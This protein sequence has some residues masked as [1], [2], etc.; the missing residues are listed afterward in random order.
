MKALQLGSILIVISILLGACSTNSPV[1]LPTETVASSLFESPIGS[2]LTVAPPPEAPSGRILT[3]M[4]TLPL[5]QNQA[6]S[7]NPEAVLI[8]VQPSRAMQYNLGLVPGS[9]GW[10]YQFQVPS[11][12]RELF[13]QIVN[14]ELYGATVA[15]PL[16]EFDFTFQEIDTAQ[17]ALD[18]TDVLDFYLRSQE[19][20]KYVQ[21]H[22]DVEWDFRLVYPSTVPNPVWSLYDVEQTGTILLNI[23]AVTGEITENPLP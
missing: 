22:D 18:S 13:V 23:D 14:G 1:P 9:L 11:T 7:W 21:K 19:G 20:I 4:E 8:G 5:A 6:R 2:N 15:R 17:I 12:K 3:A 10:F 16:G